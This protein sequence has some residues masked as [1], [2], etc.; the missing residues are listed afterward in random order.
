M[1]LVR[2]EGV[3]RRYLLGTEEV[4]ALRDV[5]LT[6]ERG[7]FM[8][9]AGP[10]GSGKTTLLNLI[11][12]IDTPT[13]GSIVIDGHDVSGRTPDQLAELRARTI[14]FV[15]QTF[16][17]LPVLSARENVEYPLLQMHE[18]SRAERR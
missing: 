3:S 11:G 15:F 12:C 5:S 13:S 1:P 6:V 17:L 16:N 14:G 10:S 18:L 9:I 7:V 8:A 2:V 4:W